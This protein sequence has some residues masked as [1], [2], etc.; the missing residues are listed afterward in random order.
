LSC[1]LEMMVIVRV[2][3]NT[4]QTLADLG[5]QQHLNDI[6]WTGRLARAFRDGADHTPGTFYPTAIE[7]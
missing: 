4:H 3:L 2:V 6:V 1:Q 5:D 7:R